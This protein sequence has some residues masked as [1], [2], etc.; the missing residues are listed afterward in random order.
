MQATDSRYEREGIPVG[1][2]KRENSPPS[3]FAQKRC[4]GIV[5]GQM[6]SDCLTAGIKKPG[7]KLA[8]DTIPC[9]APTRRTGNEDDLCCCGSCRL[10][11]PGERQ[12]RPA[13]PAMAFHGPHR[14]HAA[15]DAPLVRAEHTPMGAVPA[16]GQQLEGYMDDQMMGE[17]ARCCEG[18]RAKWPRHETLHS[19]G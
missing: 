18:A 8:G 17:G 11:H 15:C 16:Q 7:G 6:S 19:R 5:C 12:G 3:R 10:G 1:C 14:Q 2:A 4:H 9:R 13:R